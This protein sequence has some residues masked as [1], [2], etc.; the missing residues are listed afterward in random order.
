MWRAADRD[1]AAGRS[2]SSSARVRVHSPVA[3]S[4]VPPLNTSPLKPNSAPPRSVT[5]SVDQA[6][7]TEKSLVARCSKP[8]A[9]IETRTAD[10][11]LPD[12]V[13]L[14]M[15][16]ACCGRRSPCCVSTPGAGVHGAAHVEAARGSCADADVADALV[17]VNVLAIFVAGHLVCIDD[18]TVPLP[19]IDVFGHVHD[20][21][22]RSP[23]AMALVASVLSALIFEPASVL[24]Y[25]NG[26]S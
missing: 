2:R 15:A 23:A 18:F 21:G 14:A 13:Y 22:I 19:D 10:A 7:V 26:S 11:V 8:D 16:A 24:L 1:D 25:N 20:A 5:T 3:V 12:R 9:T 17:G 6:V 4:S